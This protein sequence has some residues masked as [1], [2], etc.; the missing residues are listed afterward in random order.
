MK[1]LF[2]FLLVCVLLTG[3]THHRTPAATGAASPTTPSLTTG[4]CVETDLTNETEDAPMETISNK[5]HALLPEFPAEYE[6]ADTAGYKDVTQEQFEDYVYRMEAEDFLVLRTKEG[7]WFA[8]PVTHTVL[9]REDCILDFHQEME[10][11]QR[12]SV[13]VYAAARDAEPLDLDALSAK[14]AAAPD[15]TYGVGLSAYTG[16]GYPPPRTAP[17]ELVFALTTSPASMLKQ[18]SLKRCVCIESD[19]D[20]GLLTREVLVSDGGA[21]YLHH[22]LGETGLDPVCAD[23]DG[24]GTDEYIYW[25]Y[26]PTSGLFTVALWAW[27]M[28]DGLPV[29][30]ATTILNLTFGGIRLEVLDGRANLCIEKTDC[31]PGTSQNT[32]AE[33][34]RLPLS[35]RDGQLLVNDGELPKG[36]EYWE[37]AANGIPLCLALSA[38]KDLTCAEGAE[39]ICDSGRAFFWKA[40]AGDGAF[41]QYAAFSRDGAR[42]T[43]TMERLS[44]KDGSEYI[45]SSGFTPLWEEPDLDELIGLTLEELEARL[46]PAHYDEGSGVYLLRWLTKDG[47]LLNV[48]CID[49][50]VSASLYDPLTGTTL[51]DS[52]EKLPHPNDPDGVWVSYHNAEP[53]SH[54]TRWEE[55]TANVDAGM[56]DAINLWISYDTGLFKLQLR[57]DGD[58]FYLTD[59]GRERSFAHLICSEDQNPLTLE[60]YESAVHW[61][62]SDDPEMDFDRY[63]AHMVSSQ[64]EFDFPNT[65]LLFSV[66]QNQKNNT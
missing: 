57:Y 34:L 37:T 13:R 64:L 26:G 11:R 3:C 12:F 31:H 40:E 48:S 65:R 50:V 6:T 51:R 38:A 59:E 39:L 62:L 52:S 5:L 56:P 33:A 36:M 30:K 19:P 16:T 1:R 10:D 63:L 18:T 21:G 53:I 23:L 25:G 7:P 32:T 47:K 45:I 49:R 35:I 24:D 15:G 46:G 55:F 17:K 22:Y 58:R 2:T 60:H 28:E 14:L 27:G 66:Y 61:L 29:V 54:E 20:L 8:N 9:C 44:K 43:G 4:V 42:V 41:R